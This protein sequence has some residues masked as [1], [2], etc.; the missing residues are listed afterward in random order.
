M[1]W[2]F[3]GKGEWEAASSVDT[4][5][6]NPMWRVQVCDDGT[7]DVSATDEE[8]LQ[9]RKVKTFSTLKIAQSY[10]ASGEAARVAIQVG[11]SDPNDD[12]DKEI[13]A[14]T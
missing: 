11:R 1:Q 14:S 7:F 3:D 2:K 10:C 8:L 12:I 9:Y 4:Y 13:E 6:S 5:G